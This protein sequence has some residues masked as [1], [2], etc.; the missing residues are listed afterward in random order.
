MQVAAMERMTREQE[1]TLQQYER[2]RDGTPSV[3]GTLAAAAAK[4]TA[5]REA[6]SSVLAGDD[7]GKSSHATARGNAPCVRRLGRFLSVLLQV[8]KE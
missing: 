8:S 3:S 5:Q 4:D 2:A 1:T 7:N 6:I